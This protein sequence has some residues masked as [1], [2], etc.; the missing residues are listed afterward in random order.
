MWIIAGVL[1][2]IVVL[3]ALVGFHSGP[4]AHAV[5]GGVGVLAAAWLVFMAIDGR[6]APVLWA[7]LS[8]DVVVSAGVGVMGWK[9]LA[10]R[11]TPP[12]ELSG[13]LEGAEGVAVGDLNPEGIVRIR[14]EQWSAVSVN[15]TVPAGG[16]VQV[17]RA[18]GVRLEVWGEDAAALPVSDAFSLDR[19]EAESTEHNQ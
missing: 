2:G 16:R 5:A 19:A 7:L 11:D 9:G 18:A 8:A 13:S 15:G 12:P 14:G 4:H 10:A 17:L 3:A 6:S 1:L